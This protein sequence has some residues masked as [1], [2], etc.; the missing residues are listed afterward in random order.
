MRKFSRIKTTLIFTAAFVL[1]TFLKATSQNPNVEI[2]LDNPAISGLDNAMQLTHAGDGTNRIFIAERA[3]TVKVVLPA[4]PT[5]AVPFLNMNDPTAIV[6]S[7]DGEDGLLSIAFHPQ[8]ETNGFFYVYYTNLGG[9][10]VVARYTASGNTATSA[11]YQQVLLIPHPG[12]TNHNGGELHFG[13]DGF[14]YLSTG[15]GGGAN[16]DANNAQN[17]GTWLGK[18]LRIDVNVP[19]GAPLPYQIPATNPIPGSPVFAL[20]LRNPFRWSFDR[21]TGDMWI[22]D[23]GQGAREEIDFRPPTLIANSNFGWRCFEGDIPTPGIDQ[24]GCLPPENYVAPLYAYTNG[25]D[26]GR[27]VIGGVVYRGTAY[28][29]M[30]GFYIGTDYFS[31]DI[32][33]ILRSQSYI[34]YEEGQ[35]A[36]TVDIGEDEAGEI[37]AVKANAVYQIYAEEPMPVRLANFQ[38]EKGNEGINLTWNTTM[39]EAFGNF[40]VEFSTNARNFENVGTVQAANHATGSAYRFSHLTKNT[41]NLYYRLKMVDLDETFEYSRIITVKTDEKMAGA[42]VRPTIIND[43][44]LNLNLDR[45]FQFVELVNA[46]G[47]V[48]LREEITGKSGEISIPL[49]E[50]TSGL[51]IVRLEDQD[52]IVQQKVIVTD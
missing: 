8:F 24:T 28:P 52:G 32:H 40:E 33:K 25:D 30:Y 34:G 10:L 41:G 39:E 4:A 1:F 44:K 21:L 50:A 7:A 22:G 23:V 18:I 9:N 16:D 20:G 48:F 47:Q 51:Y 49:H 15:D 5:T 12:A 14:L 2:D 26:R 45:S 17:P 27:S 37:Y 43:N 29:L 38:G 42:Y 46:S 13:Q 19:D 6:R 31:G 11:S 3:G 36:G 35:L